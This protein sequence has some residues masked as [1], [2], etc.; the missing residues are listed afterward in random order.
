VAGAVVGVSVLGV[1]CLECVLVCC[2]FGVFC[3]ASCVRDW[4]CHVVS[5]WLSVSC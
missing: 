2:T 5:E 1:V 3:R 4:E